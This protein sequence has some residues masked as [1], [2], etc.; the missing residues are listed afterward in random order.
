M[1]THC[2]ATTLALLC[3]AALHHQLST[4][5]AQAPAFTYQGRLTENGSPASGLYDLRF[6]I[7]NLG[8]SAVAGPQTNSAVAVSNG[9]FTVMLDFGS[10]P[11]DG[12]ARWLEIGVRPNG[13]AGAYQ[14]LSPRQPLT[15]APYAIHAATA[16]N[17]A[18]ANAATMANA[19]PWSGLTG[20]PSGFADAIDNDTTY[21]AGIGLSLADTTFRLDT[22]FTDG[23]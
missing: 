4:L 15:P 9:V 5:H 18:T 7:F 16:A 2:T 20:L 23:Q 17:A 19:T 3:L 11:F 14:T 12:S 8:G 10:V 1:R 22:N 21:A 13:S 6:T